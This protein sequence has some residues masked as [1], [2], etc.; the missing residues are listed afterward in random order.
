[1]QAQGGMRWMLMICKCFGISPDDV[2]LER[3]VPSIVSIIYV[4]DLHVISACCCKLQGMH[5]TG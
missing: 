2:A 1:M 5:Y 3:L 4:L